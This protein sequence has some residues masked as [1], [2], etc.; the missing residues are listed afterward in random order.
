MVCQSFSLS[1]LIH[2]TLLPCSVPW[3][4][5]ALLIS[6]K[7][8]L[9]PSCI[10][11]MGSSG[12]TMKKEKVMRSVYLVPSLWGCQGLPVSFDQGLSLFKVFLL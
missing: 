10:Q 6:I 12:R 3:K 4:G 9:A 2:S 8:L 1:L 11:P 7:G 5:K